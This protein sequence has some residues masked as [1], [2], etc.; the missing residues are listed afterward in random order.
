MAS[1]RVVISGSF[2]RDAQSLRADADALVEAGCQIIAPRSL[3]FVSEV[4]GFV[5][6]AGE[7]ELDP[8]SIEGGHLRAITYAD[9]VW[10]HLPEDI[11]DL[12][13]LSSSDGPA[14]SPSPSS[15]AV[16]DRRS[17]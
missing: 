8:A 15:H 6:S 4:E 13:A 3:D 17:A 11:S 12:P 14:L 10:L 7:Q 16:R 5:M 1:A 9:F 2:R